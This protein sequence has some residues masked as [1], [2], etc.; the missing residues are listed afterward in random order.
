MEINHECVM[1]KFRLQLQY[2]PVPQ[3]T[4][5][6]YRAVLYCEGKEVQVYKSYASQVEAKLEYNTV[7]KTVESMLAMVDK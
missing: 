3:Y 4:W 6:Y 1:G 5:S 7:K 2:F